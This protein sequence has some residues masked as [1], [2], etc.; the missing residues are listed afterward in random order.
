[1]HTC[2]GLL[3]ASPYRFVLCT[4]T[5]MY[6]VCVLCI[7]VCPGDS[8]VH[9][10][11]EQQETEG[12]VCTVPT[13]QVSHPSPSHHGRHQRYMYIY[14]WKCVGYI[15]LHTCACT[16]VH[17]YMYIHVYMYANQSKANGS[18]QRQKSWTA[19]SGTR[20]CNLWL[21]WPALY[22]LRHMYMNV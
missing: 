11:K 6:I 21:S 15:C 7:G 19:L 22:P 3:G 8:D 20:T 5:N 10:A 13:H 2:C 14:C 9:W 1:M 4:C 16:Y 18:T 12:T 17:L